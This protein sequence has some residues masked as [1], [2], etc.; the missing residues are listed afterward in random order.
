M[1]RTF[2]AWRVLPRHP[3]AR[4]IRSTVHLAT[5]TPR[6]RSHPHALTAP[7]RDSGARRPFEPGSKIPARSPVTSASRTDRRDGGLLFLAQ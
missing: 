2:R 3:L 4:M 7:W 1:V 5:A 6:R